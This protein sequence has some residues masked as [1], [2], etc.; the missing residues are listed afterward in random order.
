LAFY[1]TT[2][3]IL[4]VVDRENVQNNFNASMISGTMLKWTGV[5]MMSGQT[6]DTVKKSM[7][8]E[9]EQRRRSEVL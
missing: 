1:P 7:E 2:C 4:K 3:G 8:V 5:Q 6:T 9:I